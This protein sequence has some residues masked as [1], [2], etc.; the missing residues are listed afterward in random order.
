MLHHESSAAIALG[1]GSHIATIIVRKEG[2]LCS[3]TA[4]RLVLA[5]LEF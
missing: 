4:V 3:L 5:A 2:G 1:T